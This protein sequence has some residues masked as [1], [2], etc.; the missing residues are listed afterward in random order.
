LSWF[1]VVY[2]HGHFALCCSSSVP[3][4]TWQRI[5]VQYLSR[6]GF[7]S[8]GW[9]AYL[10]LWFWPSYPKRYCS[11]VGSSVSCYIDMSSWLTQPSVG[12]WW[13]QKHRT[14]D[15]DVYPQI[16]PWIRLGALNGDDGCSSSVK[17]WGACDR[18]RH[19]HFNCAF[20]LTVFSQ[21][22]QSFPECR[23]SLRTQDVIHF[24]HFTARWE[25]DYE[26]RYCRVLRQSE[27]NDLDG[28]GQPTVSGSPFCLLHLLVASYSTNTSA[29]G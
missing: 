19:F 9:T 1:P 5:H 11:C 27:Q 25:G 13:N 26:R 3:C 22:L 29:V 7:L 10:K 28:A 23:S 4:Y 6:V 8:R 14:P 12:P 18:C 24:R 15:P 2:L 20:S 16:P 21:V 17:M